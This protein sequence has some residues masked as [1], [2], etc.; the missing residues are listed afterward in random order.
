MSIDAATAAAWLVTNLQRL[1]LGRCVLRARLPGCRHQRHRPSKRPQAPAIPHRAATP[2]A[3][4]PQRREWPRRPRRL[5]GASS[6]QRPER[7]VIFKICCLATHTM[8]LEN[9]SVS[10]PK[11]LQ[12]HLPQTPCQRLL[13]ISREMHCRTCGYK[14]CLGFTNHTLIAPTNK[15]R[16]APR[17]RLLNYGTPR[18]VKTTMARCC[19]ICPMGTHIGPTTRYFHAPLPEIVKEMSG[20]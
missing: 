6:P 10:S 1:V 11:A 17:H 9:T 3:V 18:R 4:V 15:M 14:H 5:R 2:T 13:Q 16:N 20:N 8:A 12:Y 19:K 7:H